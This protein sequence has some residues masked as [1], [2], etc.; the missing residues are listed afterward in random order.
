MCS[1]ALLH[2][3]VKEVYYIFPRTKGGG[4]GEISVHDR[5]DLN[6]RFEVW[7]WMG[8]LD[9]AT[10]EALQIDEDVAI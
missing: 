10:R 7:R 9:E 2:S 8:E 6:H 5:K 4:F 1:M 3:R